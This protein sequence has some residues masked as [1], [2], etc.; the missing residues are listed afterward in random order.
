MELLYKILLY[1]HII[2]G[3]LALIGGSIAMLSKKGKSTHRT[4]GK[5]FFYSM[6]LVCF[7]AIS[8]SI[9]KN[10]PFLLMIGIFALFQNYFGFRAI[11]NKS[12][13]YKN[14]DKAMLLIACINSIFML[15]SFM[16]VLMVFGGISVMLCI[17]QIKLYVATLKKQEVSKKLWLR[18]H[19]GMMMGA[20]I[21]TLTAFLVVNVKSFQPGWLIWL[22]PTILLVPL[23]MF[24]TKKYTGNSFK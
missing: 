24:W 17:G 6:L 5:V 12:L 20:Y 4:S 11:I 2:T 3:G 15:I 10:I 8:I 23:M 16:P 18:Q 13:N 9:L 1:I 19:I 21:A 14:I 7:S 22:A